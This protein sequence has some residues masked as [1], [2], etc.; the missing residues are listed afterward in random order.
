MRKSVVKIFVGVPGDAM[1]ARQIT[2]DR[3]LNPIFE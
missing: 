1:E 3:T 2:V